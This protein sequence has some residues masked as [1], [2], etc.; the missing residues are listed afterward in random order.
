VFL[1][2][3]DPERHEN[4]VTDAGRDLFGARAMSSALAERL[5]R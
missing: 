3:H 4:P 1:Y 2:A 5:I